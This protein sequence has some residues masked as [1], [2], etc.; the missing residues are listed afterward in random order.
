M[1][2]LGVPQEDIA[3]SIGISLPTLHK[4]YRSELDTG[5][6][7][8][9]SAVAQSLFKKA[10]G[11]GQSSVVAAIFWAK[12][13]MGWTDTTKLELDGKLIIEINDHWA[14]T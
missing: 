8:A 7:K 1:S 14:K 10:I 2:G 6:V 12:T 11:D 5:R 3:L 9:N 13:Q 4:Y